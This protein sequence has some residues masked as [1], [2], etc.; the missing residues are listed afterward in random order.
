MCGKRVMNNAETKRQIQNVTF[1]HL[2]KNIKWSEE[3]L[4]LIL[5][6]WKVN[7]NSTK[8]QQAPLVFYKSLRQVSHFLKPFK[9]I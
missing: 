8:I 3:D 2:H 4:Y 5:T 1:Y 6:L 7:A 9:N